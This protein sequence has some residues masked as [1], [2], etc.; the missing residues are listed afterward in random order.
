MRKTERLTLHFNLKHLEH[1]PKDQ[2]YFICGAVKRKS[3]KV[4]TKETRT[5]HATKNKA[6]GMMEEEQLNCYT[7][8]LEEV[9]LPAD[10]VGFHWI[11]Y[12]SSKPDAVCDEIA[13]VFNYIPEKDL[14]LAA[15]N[16]RKD[17]DLSAPPALLSCGIDKIE[18]D[19]NNHQ[20]VWVDAHKTIDS[21]STAVSLVMMHPD[22]RTSIPASHARINYQIVQRA[23]A[24]SNLKNYISLNQPDNPN[25]TTPWYTSS[26][27][28]D[29]DGNVMSPTDGLVDK[30]GNPIVWPTK[31]FNGKN[32]SYISQMNLSDDLINVVRPV[33]QHSAQQVKKA[34]WL[35]GQNWHTQHGI[36]MKTNKNVEQTVACKSD[37]SLQRESTAIEPVVASWGLTQLTSL[38]G[39]DICGVPTY[40]AASNTLTLSVQ[41]W[42]NRGL[43]VYVQFFDVN[44]VPIEKPNDWKNNAYFDWMQPNNTK[45]FLDH[46]GSGNT[47]F[48]VPVLTDTTDISVQ[49]PNN[50]YGVDFL[51]GG[52]GNG[53]YD[54]D[55]DKVGIIYTCFVSYGI[56]AFL[57]ILSVGVQSQ[58][59]YVNFFKKKENK[60]ALYAV[61]F[62]LIAPYIAVEAAEHKTSDLLC[63][64]G[65]FVEQVLLNKELAALALEITGYVTAE[66]LLQAVPFVGWALKI[67]SCASSIADMVATSVE[68]AKSP[69][70]YRIRAKRSMN[71]NVVVKPDPTH[72]TSGEKPIWPEV[73]D[74][75]IITVQYKS[76]TTFR[77]TGPMPGNSSTNIEVSFCS[78]SGD[79]IPSAPDEKFQITAEIYSS[80]N[81]I[82]G[83]WISGWIQAVPTGVSTRTEEG[84]IIERLVPLTSNTSYYHKEKLNY[85]DISKSYIWQKSVFNID[86]SLESYF[87]AGTLSQNII[88]EFWSN[89]VRL[90]L[91]ASIQKLTDQ[92]W[93]I[94]DINT[95]YM[96]I[97]KSIYNDSNTISSYELEVKNIT[98]ATPVGTI[99]SLANNDIKALTGITINNLACKLGYAYQGQNQDIPLDYGNSNQSEPMYLLE[100]ISTLAAPEVGMKYP[101][102]GFSV[103]S[104]L[105]YDQFGP[106]GLFRIENIDNY[107]IEL[108]NGGNLS[109]DI[110]E[111]FTQNGYVLPSGVKSLKIEP[112]VSW[113]IGVDE[114]NLIYTL[115]RV[116]DTIVVFR[117]TSSEP[118]ANNFFLDSR[119]Y[120]DTKVSQLRWVDLSVNTCDKGKQPFNYDSGL[121]YGAFP[122]DGIDELVVHPN[123]Y[124]IGICYDCSNM[125]ILQL[126]SQPIADASAP[127]AIPFSGLGLREGLMNGPK[128]ITIT[129]DGR[130]LILESIN[131]RIQAF[132]IMANPVQCFAGNISFQTNVDS[133]AELDDFGN[134][135]SLFQILQNQVPVF[136][137]DPTILDKRCLLTSVFSMNSSFVDILN[138]GNFTQDLQTQFSQNGIFTGTN[139][140]I[141]KTADNIWMIKDIDFGMYWDVRYN[142][143]G[144]EQVDVY[145][146]FMLSVSVIAKGEEWI[147]RDK[148]N[149]LTFE[150][151]KQTDPNNS[152]NVYL[153]F[154]RMVS[155]MKLKD[156]PTGDTAIQYL[157]LA[158]E[159]KGFIYVLAYTNEGN[160]SSDY[161]IDIYNPDGTP[162]NS[163][164][165]NHNGNVNGAK[166]TVDQWRTLFTLNYEQ[167]HG[168]GGRPEPTISQ[169]IPTTP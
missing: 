68:V 60:I 129:I 76:G 94:N 36:T 91:N 93:Q 139:I 143:E 92:S 72:G 113:Q 156:K 64:A 136:E 41:N 88:D 160:T 152:S 28:K 99:T 162:V 13:A 23:P 25:V 149:T 112:N 117:Y 19:S 42:A 84:A 119:T 10:A 70:T 130:I 141:T 120:G 65:Q 27:A 18:G 111:L 63:K 155:I 96:V 52:L 169:W 26:Y 133:A 116:V 37:F 164:P 59:W 114:Q 138:E 58:Q 66:E 8:F 74:H 144:D 124:V 147:I 46:I 54:S 51:F 15:D 4:H 168:D 50:A 38:Y 146:G 102:R 107:M 2:E 159:N 34:S 148:T 167:M 86:D 106:G 118:S 110:V 80:N 56:P 128:A 5:Y 95:S 127:M 89:G 85:D 151:K 135:D 3:L 98:F 73:S 132:D 104:A 125:F 39:I 103:Q 101:S 79:A 17:G 90:S 142:G 150:V 6:L 20:D 53:N 153:K 69:S 44:G 87:E 45:L 78:N 22:I 75:F 31:N 109:E 47:V 71:L 158:V 122:V 163:D 67:A 115:R 81:W 82:A 14:R 83:K 62:F 134:S 77:K 16:M 57:D 1:L 32:S 121:S 33:V 55:V 166:M 145:R 61:A 126:P 165:M 97:K 108:N 21:G 154:Q 7:H 35:K 12:K 11:A 105:A 9:E 30:N 43:G 29:A 24:F 100:S 49:M 157:D 48:G 131:T 140:T 161:R 137:P 123:G 40:D